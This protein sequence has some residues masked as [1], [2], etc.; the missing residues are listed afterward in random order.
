MK[1]LAAT[2]F[3]FCFG[4]LYCNEMTIAA[5]IQK[6]GLENEVFL[7]AGKKPNPFRLNFFKKQNGRKKVIA[8]ML[9]FPLPFGFLGA[10]RIYLGTK[11]YIPLVYVGTLGGCAGLIPLIDFIN[12]VCSKDISRFQNNPHIFMWIDNEPKK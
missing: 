3:G 7:S 9:A 10:H 6:K 1:F 8:A 12:L 11:P 4:N 2:F 5:G